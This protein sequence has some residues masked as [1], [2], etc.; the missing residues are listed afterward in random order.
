MHA[1][2]SD[3]ARE[4]CAHVVAREPY[5]LRRLARWLDSDGGPI[6]AMDGSVESFFSL[7]S[8]YL[9]F[10]ERDLPGVES[11]VL[12]SSWPSPTQF[13]DDGP[14]VPESMSRERRI[15]Y[16]SECLAHY[17]RL[18]VE[19]DRG[20][21]WWEPLVSV[22]GSGRP[23]RMHHSSVIVYDGGFL[24]PGFTTRLALIADGRGDYSGLQMIRDTLLRSYQPQGRAA[25]GSPSILAPY[26][27]EPLPEEPVE[28]R[29]SPVVFWSSDWWPEESP[30]QQRNRAARASVAGPA[31]APREEMTLADGPG[32]GL[33]R[34][35]L[36]AP[37]DHAEAA[38]VL[39]AAGFRGERGLITPDD[40]G[41][42]EAAFGHVEAAGEVV[43]VAHEG[44][45]RALH[46]EPGD[47]P[48]VAWRRAVDGLTRFAETAG[49]RFVPDDQFDA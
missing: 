21:A 48:E 49:A 32:E 20:A 11:D 12:P 27:T 10:I 2:T 14:G 25:P 43:S 15:G 42:E 38:A 31:V 41:A 24:Y 28:A 6:D 19:R 3:Q 37:L 7:W 4:Y 35:E 45:L 5:R 34:L 13:E 1:T 8:W 26:L 18:V 33:E 46:L 44:A 39:N 47:G 36:L 30:A 16:V 29:V 9:G 40:L 23:D 17:V 22:S